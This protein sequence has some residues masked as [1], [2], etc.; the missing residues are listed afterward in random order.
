METD[1]TQS[2]FELV[3]ISIIFRIDLEGYINLSAPIALAIYTHSPTAYEALR[4]F[5]ILQLPGVS[6]LKTFTSFNLE[7]PGFSEE[8]LAAGGKVP[9]SEGILVFDEVKVGLKLHYHA[10]TGQ[11]IG[12][13]MSSDELG[14]LHDVY[15]TL[16]PDHRMQKASYVLQFLWRCTAS[17]FDILG[18][19]Y[20]SPETNTAKFILATLLDTMG[21]LQLY[22]FKTKATVS[23]G[24]ST[25]L[26]AIKLL[27]GFGSGA[28]GNK[29]VGSCD[30]IHE[31][32]LGSSIP[33]PT[34][35]CL[36]SFVP[37]IRYTCI[38]LRH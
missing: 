3:G 35:R 14:S 6:T 38:L 25:N 34:R 16:Q 20:T 21:A 33:T 37:P 1:G 18:P 26:L 4:G 7:N 11:F 17:D 10:K 15:Q 23:D 2:L 28:F 5:G 13:A 27:T 22:G 30:D 8:R 31:V 9:F 36:P 19:Y 32:K 12:L 29:P 24:A